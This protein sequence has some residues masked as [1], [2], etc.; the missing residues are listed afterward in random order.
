MHH[1]PI[2]DTPTTGRTRRLTNAI[3]Q[4]FTSHEY[5][6]WVA[7]LGFAVGA[8]SALR[9]NQLSPSSLQDVYPAGFLRAWGLILCAGGIL[10]FIGLARRNYRIRQTGI[11]LLGGCTAVVTVS[12]IALMVRGDPTRA[13]GVGTYGLFTAACISRFRSLGRLADAEQNA[14]KAIHD[15]E[16]P[17]AGRRRRGRRQRRPI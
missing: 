14:L 11:T 7:W 8:G 1:N 12:L 10:K 13:F 16:N 17:P 15:V 3:T 4:A 6:V 9:P 2:T 5:E